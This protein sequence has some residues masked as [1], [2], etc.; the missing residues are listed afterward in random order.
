MTGYISKLRQKIGKEKFIH[1]AARI[2]IE[3]EKG[4]FLFVRRVDNGN[5]GIPAGAFEENETIEQCIIREVKEETG[6]DI[7]SMDLIGISSNP[8]VET[9]SYPNGDT[10][11]YFSI[12]FYS[13]NWKGELKINDHDEIK[14][15]K[16]LEASWLHKLPTSEKSILDSLNY[17]RKEKKVRLK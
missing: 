17:Y 13:N 2:L 9:V 6:L 16:F 5:L 12:E 11:Q 10:I 7:V 14:N 4:E 8:D 3:N 15:L 1:P